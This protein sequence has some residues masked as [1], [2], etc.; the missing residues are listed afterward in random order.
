MT[1]RRGQKRGDEDRGVVYRDLP[2]PRLACRRCRC[3]ARTRSWSR[4]SSGSS[5][6]GRRRAFAVR[7]CLVIRTCGMP[8]LP[9]VGCPLIVTVEDRAAAARCLHSQQPSLLPAGGHLGIPASRKASCPWRG[10]LPAAAAVSSQGVGRTPRVDRLAVA[11]FA[12]VWPA[13]ARRPAAQ[14]ERQWLG[15][16]SR[17]RIQRD[18][19]SPSV[20]WVG[21]I[22]MATSRARVMLAMSVTTWG[23]ATARATTSTPE[24]WSRLASPRGGQRRPRPD[25]R[26][27]SSRSARFDRHAGT[28]GLAWMGEH[29]RAAER[30]GPCAGGAPGG[31]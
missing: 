29:R 7:C 23:S 13:I 3:L 5:G 24:G 16:A 19:F 20:E 26:S 28:S 8:H 2:G 18:A 22:R 21:G 14:Q 1:R 25:Q 17:T 30:R 11:V 15:L 6:S 9:M 4:G 12:E 31:G 27:G 10:A